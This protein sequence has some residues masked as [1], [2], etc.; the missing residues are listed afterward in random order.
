VAGFTPSNPMGWAPK[1]PVTSKQLNHT[2]QQIVKAVNGVDGGAYDGPLEL[3]DIELM[4]NG[5]GGIHGA[6][7][8]DTTGKITTT[9]AI[10]AGV[11][12]GSRYQPEDI[13]SIMLVE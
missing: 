6:G 3:S 1:D 7:K 13:S 8:I 4:P 5:T 2:D 10:T 9:K 12:K 11:V